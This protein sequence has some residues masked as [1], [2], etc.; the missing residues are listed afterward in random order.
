MLVVFMLVA[1]FCLSVQAQNKGASK[2]VINGG[3]SGNVPF[4]HGLH[5]EKLPECNACHD[6]FPQKAGIIDELKAKGEMKS[7]TVM[8]NCQKCHRK[9]KRAGLKTGPVSCKK[10]H[11]I[12]G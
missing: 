6:L 9:T 2:M 10:C 11:S 1:V 7:K 12:K 4:P 8:N 3:K 5:Q